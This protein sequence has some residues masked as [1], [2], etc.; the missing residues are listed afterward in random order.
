MAV[1]AGGRRQ[2]VLVGQHGAFPRLDRWNGLVVALP[3]HCL[4]C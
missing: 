4:F 3:S 1:S 2:P